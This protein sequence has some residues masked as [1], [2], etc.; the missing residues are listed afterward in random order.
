MPMFLTIGYGDREG[1]EATAPEQ[2]DKAHAHDQ[3]LAS[4]GA[5]IG[6]AGTPTQ[7]RNPEGSGITRTGGS[8]MQADL[9]LA[10]FALLEAASLEEAVERV[11]D[12]PCAVAHGVVEVW[13][14]I[15]TLDTNGQNGAIPA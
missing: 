3:W 9:P 8:Y 10:G 4:H 2:R 15:C 11:A 7:V 14:L 1:Y 13:P 6:A 12:T 5:V